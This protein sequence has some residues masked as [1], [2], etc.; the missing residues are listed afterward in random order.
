MVEGLKLAKYYKSQ[1]VKAKII[2]SKVKESEWQE[3]NMVIRA[4]LK[5]SFLSC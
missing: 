3:L 2:K 4:F 1:L 5:I